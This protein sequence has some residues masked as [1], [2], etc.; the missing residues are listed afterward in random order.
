[1]TPDDVTI[2][3]DVRNLS[4]AIGRDPNNVYHNCHAV[5]LAIVQSG[6]YPGT[7]VAR[8]FAKG[9]GMAQHSWVVAGDPYDKDAHIIDATLW[10]YDPTVKGVWQGT[11]RD[12]IHRPHGAGHFL[13]ASAPRH[14]GGTTIHLNTVRLSPEARQF[15]DAIDAPFDYQGWSEVAHLPVEGWP[16]GEV[17][18]AMD[19]TPTLGALV[20]IDVLGMTTELNPSNLYMKGAESIGWK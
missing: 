5:S 2:P 8:G 7:R 13:T 6:I 9:V 20:P 4:N 16:A 12:G 19:A 10:S 17:F 1:M 15:L 11:M 3:E 14:H 18:A